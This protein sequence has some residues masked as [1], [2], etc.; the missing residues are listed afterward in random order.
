MDIIEKKYSDAC[1]AINWIKLLSIILLV[2][3]FKWGEIFL[4]ERECTSIQKT[5]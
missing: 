4:N 2:I 3:N 5:E 1:G